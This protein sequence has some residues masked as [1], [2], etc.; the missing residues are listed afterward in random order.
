MYHKRGNT[1]TIAHACIQYIMWYQHSTFQWQYPLTHFRAPYALVDCRLGCNAFLFRYG[2]DD[3]GHRWTFL[4]KILPFLPRNRFIVRI[5][6]NSIGSE[7]DIVFRSFR[8]AES[9]FKNF[10]WCLQRG[11]TKWSAKIIFDLC[12]FL[13]GAWGPIF[14]Q[15]NFKKGSNLKLARLNNLYRTNCA[16]HSK[17]L[18][19]KL[20][21]VH[22][23]W[24]EMSIVDI[25]IRWPVSS[26]RYRQ[27]RASSVLLLLCTAW[28]QILQNLKIHSNFQYT[29]VYTHTEPQ[30][31]FFQQ[32]VV[33]FP[34]HK[35]H[36]LLNGCL[37]NLCC[38]L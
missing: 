15:L 21:I 1:L 34:R 36:P 38:M 3:K 11:F 4:W 17:F 20:K 23:Y 32:S 14:T 8:S 10:D 25:S 33:F 24:V 27:R 37:V 2:C 6:L 19:K 35:L 7:R 31:S 5:E 13:F 29:N 30:M 28:K 26:E 12:R 18:G 16:H 22:V 9:F